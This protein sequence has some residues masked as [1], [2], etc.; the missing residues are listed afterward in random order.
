MSLSFTTMVQ[1]LIP[2]AYHLIIPFQS[3]FSAYGILIPFI[4]KLHLF[5]SKNRKLLPFLCFSGIGTLIC[6]QI[7]MQSFLCLGFSDSEEEAVGSAPSRWGKKLTDQRPQLGYSQ[8][9]QRET[10]LTRANINCLL[11]TIQFSLL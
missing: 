8:F 1:L 6:S 4:S 11:K 7:L 10:H 3:Q 9:T 2:S 5:P